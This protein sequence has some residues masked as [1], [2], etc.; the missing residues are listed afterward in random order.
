MF[1][2]MLLHEG[3]RFFDFG[4]IF[5]DGIVKRLAAFLNKLLNGKQKQFA[6]FKFCASPSPFRAACATTKTVRHRGLRSYEISRRTVV[7]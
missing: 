7:L 4:V 5:R 6:F 2:K 3:A 1:R